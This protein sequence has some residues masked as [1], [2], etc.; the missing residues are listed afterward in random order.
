VLPNGLFPKESLVGF[1]Y[2][3]MG[4]SE[5]ARSALESALILLEEEAAERPDDA[6]VHSA[7]GIVHACLGRKEEALREGKLGVELYPISRDAMHGPSQVE[8][9][10]QIYM[11]IGDHDA[12]LDKVEYLLSIP[13][14]LYAPLLRIDPVWDPLRDHPRFQQ[15]LEQY[16]GTGS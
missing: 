11:L 14:A 4:Q 1:A 8:Y 12:A 15:L 16:L 6:R 3:Y 9:L 7:L 13:D 2:M 5:L 10:A